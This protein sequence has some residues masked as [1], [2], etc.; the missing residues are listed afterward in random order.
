MLLFRKQLKLI[1]ITYTVSTLPYSLSNPY[2]GKSNGLP[3]VTFVSS[4]LMSGF[5]FTP[6]PEK[7]QI[8]A[9]LLVKLCY[10]NYI[11][12]INSERKNMPNL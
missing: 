9:K 10:S 7:K 11:Q 1:Y 3:I 2:E 5:S 6:D 8:T 4:I 12:I